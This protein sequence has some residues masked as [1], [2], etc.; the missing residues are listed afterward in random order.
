MGVGS[1]VLLSWERRKS[2]Y[3]LCLLSAG[4]N[5]GLVVYQYSFANTFSGISNYKYLIVNLV[6][7]QLV[8]CSGNFCLIAPFPDHFLLLPLLDMFFICNDGMCSIAKPK[9]FIFSD[10]IYLP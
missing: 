7:L 8:F 2:V 3:S 6:F 4:D 9:Q 10:G 5:D 1:I